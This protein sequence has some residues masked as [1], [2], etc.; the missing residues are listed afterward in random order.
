M[1]KSVCFNLTLE[2]DLLMK[3]IAFIVLTLSSFM[4]IACGENEIESV[5]GDTDGK[6][7]VQDNSGLSDTSDLVGVN[8]VDLPPITV[9]GFAYFILVFRD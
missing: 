6:Y 5:I 7:S 1:I 3:K 9:T 4:A 8:C 2:G